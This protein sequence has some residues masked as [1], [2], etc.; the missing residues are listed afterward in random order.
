MNN[1]VESSR[2]ENELD[3]EAKKIEKITEKIIKT[4]DPKK[5]EKLIEKL[6]KQRDD[7]DGQ[8]RCTITTPEK[9]MPEAIDKKAKRN[10]EALDLL[11]E[12]KQIEKDEENKRKMNEFI[13]NQHPYQEE[14]GEI[15]KNQESPTEGKA[16]NGSIVEV[17]KTLGLNEEEVEKFIK[18]AEAPSILDTLGEKLKTKI[19]GYSKKGEFSDKIEKASSN[20]SQEAKKDVI[21]EASKMET[22]EDSSTQQEYAHSLLEKQKN[23]VSGF[24]PKGYFSSLIGK[25]RKKPNQE[26]INN[27]NSGSQAPVQGQ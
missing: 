21:E 3:L 2:V 4:K 25:F 17:L 24:A 27:Q 8:Y 6:K 7:D 11:I 18:E 26:T 13:K 22:I 1:V 16:Y 10:K 9:G 23:Q 20:K 14:A 19:P 15:Y 5:K 12:T